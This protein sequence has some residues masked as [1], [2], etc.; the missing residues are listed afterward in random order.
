MSWS[1]ARAWPLAGIQFW[2]G[3]HS[4]FKDHKKTLIDPR[5]LDYDV[6][7]FLTRPVGPLVKEGSIPFLNDAQTCIRYTAFSIRFYYSR[8]G[9]LTP[10]ATWETE[11]M[12][13][14][15]VKLRCHRI[16]CNA[17]FTEDDN[18]EGSCQYHDAVW[19]LLHFLLFFWRSLKL[20]WSFR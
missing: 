20:L 1:C 11:T 18:P 8:R 10:T 5:G 12:E 6:E 15:V 17:T 16:G 7:S 2:L 13:Q 19:I 4:G 9:L 3:L 14:E